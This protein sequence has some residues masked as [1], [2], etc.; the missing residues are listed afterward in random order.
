[1]TPDL[2]KWPDYYQRNINK[3]KFKNLSGIPNIVSS[4]DGTYIAIKTLQ[5]DSEIYITRKCHYA[6]TPQS[7]CDPNTKFLIQQ[8]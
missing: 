7:I 4:I 8:T 1:M 3:L 6:I 5:E 2:I